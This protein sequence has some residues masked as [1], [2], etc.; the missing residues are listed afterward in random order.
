MMT[1]TFLQES[2]T[3]GADVNWGV[4]FKDTKDVSIFIRCVIFLYFQTLLHKNI[5]QNVDI[6]VIPVWTLPNKSLQGGLITIAV[7]W[8]AGAHFHS[9]GIRLPSALEVVF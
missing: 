4:R 7:L 2:K 1:S 8:S 5:N 3:V 6:K 9:E